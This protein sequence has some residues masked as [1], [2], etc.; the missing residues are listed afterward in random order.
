MDCVQCGECCKRFPI[1][2]TDADII[3]WLR[4]GRHDILKYFEV[5]LS[6]NKKVW[7]I[8]GDQ[9]TESD[10]LYINLDN[11]DIINPRTGDEYQTNRCP[12]LKTKGKLHFCRIHDTKPSLCE[13]FKP[14]M[15]VHDPILLNDPQFDASVYDFCPAARNSR[16]RF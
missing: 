8:R 11:H 13:D 16:N 7:W 9:L 14:W 10:V 2:A 1:W 15:W 5:C 6:K 4:S 3:R 12:F